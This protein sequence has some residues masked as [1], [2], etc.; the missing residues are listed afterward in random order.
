MRPLTC[1]SCDV[2]CCAHVWYFHLQRRRIWYSS[3]GQLVM[4]HSLY[5]LNLPIHTSGITPCMQHAHRTRIVLK[6]VKIS[7]FEWCVLFFQSLL[8]LVVYHLLQFLRGFSCC[9]WYWNKSRL[10]E[11]KGSLQ[12]LLIKHWICDKQEI[13]AVASSMLG[14]ILIDMDPL[15]SLLKILSQEFSSHMLAGK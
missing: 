8:T 11:N 5:L 6:K 13:S 2:V 15:E 3:K 10:W 9:L 14:W 7:I 4:L 1:T 12:A